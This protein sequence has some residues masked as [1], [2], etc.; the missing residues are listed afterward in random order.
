[1]VSVFYVLKD[2]EI[3]RIWE[4]LWKNKGPILFIIRIMIF[5][6]TLISKLWLFLQYLSHNSDLLC[7]KSKNWFFSGL[8]IILVT[9]SDIY[10]SILTLCGFILKFWLFFWQFQ[11]SDFSDLNPKTYFFWNNL[12]NCEFCPTFIS[13]FYF[14]LSFVTEFWLFLW[15]LF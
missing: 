12:K 3:Y 1:M 6:L 11:N 7:P 5:F 10:L 4:P 9:F 8:N 14:F 2:F 13:E 15:L